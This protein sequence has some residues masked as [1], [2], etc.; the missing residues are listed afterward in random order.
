MSRRVFVVYQDVATAYG[1]GSK[2]CMEGLLAGKSALRK[3]DRFKIPPE[4]PCT[5]GE[6][7]DDIP[8]D[9]NV[10]ELLRAKMPI[11]PEEAPVFM[12]LTVGDTAFLKNPQKRWSAEIFMEEA[13]QHLRLKKG[14]IYSAACASG[15]L[16][17]GKAFCAI[18]RNDMDVAVVA[19]ADFLS[20]FVYAGFYS[21]HALSQSDHC[22]P[23][24]RNH[25]GMLLGDAAGV[26]VLASEVAVDKYHWEPCC[27]IAGFGVATDAYHIA[28]PDPTGIGMA[29]AIRQALG[30]T[31]ASEIGAVIG[32]GTGTI[33]NDEMELQA[34]RRIFPEGVPLV[35]NKGGTGHLL[36]AAGVVSLSCAVEMLDRGVIFPSIGLSEPMAGAENFVSSRARALR[37]DRILSLNAGFGGVNYAIQICGA[38][39]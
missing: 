35:S 4:N 39:K 5:G 14:S 26:V 1:H 13:L 24:D 18:R 38:G 29:E 15:N 16:A 17:L 10:F 33:F 36:A 11:V 32:H 25:D 19:A 20:E 30:K 9:S 37:G 34:L 8:H 6:F 22:R 3:I 7:P 27:E 12:G 21:V 23:Y 28:A 2:I 31:P